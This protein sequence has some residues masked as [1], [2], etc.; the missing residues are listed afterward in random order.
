MSDRPQEKNKSRK[1]TSE[2]IEF[3]EYIATVQHFQSNYW[4]NYDD[5]KKT[6]MSAIKA[7]ALPP[8]QILK[9]KKEL[10]KMGN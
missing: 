4:F 6:I 10:K 8:R 7:G 3:A 5:K 1:L 2:E 9:F